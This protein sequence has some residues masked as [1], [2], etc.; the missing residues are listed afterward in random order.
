MPTKTTA[1][2]HVVRGV[3][4]Y[5]TSFTIANLIR[6]N[7]QSPSKLDT[8]EIYIGSVAVGM[9]VADSAEKYID[10]TIDELIAAWKEIK[11]AIE[12]A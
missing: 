2:K 3:V 5:T 6:V 10:R 12:A 4:A 11:V 9:M 7:L 8:A 1:I